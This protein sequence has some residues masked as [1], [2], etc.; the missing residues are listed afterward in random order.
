MRALAYQADGYLA[1]VCRVKA[2]HARSAQ[3]DQILK[4][5]EQMFALLSITVSLCPAMNKLL[6]DNVLSLLREK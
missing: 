1:A 2:H 6:D 3:Y 5:N 4:K